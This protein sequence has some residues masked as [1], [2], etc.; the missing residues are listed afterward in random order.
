MTETLRIVGLCND[1]RHFESRQGLRND[2]SATTLRIAPVAR[3]FESRR[4][5]RNDA[6]AST[7]AVL[8]CATKLRTGIGSHG[9]RLVYTM[10][11]NNDY[12][13]TLR[14]RLRSTSCQRMAGFCKQCCSGKQIQ[15]RYKCSGGHHHCSNAC[16]DRHGCVKSNE[17]KA[18]MVS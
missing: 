14:L 5:L 6:S 9:T 1:A 10:S 12:Y 7:P 11:D 15:A 17:T 4:G 18:K 13:S 16:I 3:L 8:G 2:T